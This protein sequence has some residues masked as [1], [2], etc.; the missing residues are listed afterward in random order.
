[1]WL[2]DDATGA[3]KLRA[4]RRWWDAIIE[5]G[6]RYG[7]YVNEDKSWLILKDPELLELAREIFAGTDIKITT[8]GKRHLGASLG[9]IEF[10]EEYVSEKVEKWCRE[11][12]R[13]SE[14]ARSQPHAAYSAYIHG[15]QHRFRFFM[16]T[17]PGM[18]VYLK[19]LDDAINLQLIPALV[20]SDVSE[21]ERAL[22][23][24]PIRDGGMGLPILTE[25]AP[26]EFLSSTTVNA[27]LAAIIT[28]QGTELPDANVVRDVVQEDRRRRAADCKIMT[29]TIDNS[30]SASTLRAVTQA[31]E[32][33]ASNWL[34]S[35]P[36]EAHGFKLNKTEFRDA[37]AIHYNNRI[38]DLPSTCVC[39]HA[40]DINHAMNCK[41]GGFV[42]IRHNEIRNF[43]ATLLSKVCCDVEIEPSLQPVT[44]EVMQARVAKGDEARLDVRARGFW[45]RGQNA[46][47]DVCVTNASA[48]SQ[49][50]QPLKSVL[51]KHEREKK[52]KYNQRVIN[53]E[54]GTLTPL[55]FTT[56]GSMGP[57]CSLFHK[58]LADKISEKTGEQYAD[59]MNF[60]RC[61]L[62]YIL[63]RS[64]ILCLR[65]SRKP[66]NADNLASVGDDFGMY[67]SELR[68]RT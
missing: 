41:R 56:S 68:L 32:K 16:R 34:S 67:A 61:K 19:P 5:I 15:E 42:T 20:G 11:I 1:M 7:Y 43:E 13:L 21:G 39:G 31:R 46:Y 25:A 44:G 58:S 48:A 50:N 62:S 40:F 49:A 22:F 17:I 33:G 37:I 52:A 2:A 53:I 12:K 38:K 8:A 26:T 60:I 23:S 57:E 14:F 18:E 55:V 59:V 66:T 64:A 30:L 27:P 6:A 35:R 4:L 47:F 29:E 63:M 54:H 28:L 36:S 10:R 65:G 51:T 45:R 9:S 3:G 24:L